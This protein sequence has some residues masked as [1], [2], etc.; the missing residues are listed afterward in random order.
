LR[1]G[2][3]AALIIGIVLAY[4][5]KIE[6][7][8]LKK[9]V[10]GG[11]AVAV[12]VSALL[13]VVFQRVA[14]NQEAFEG[15]VMLVAAV[16]V[17][18]FMEWM[19]RH[20]HRLKQGIQ[21]RID[22]LLANKSSRLAIWGLFAFAAVMVL[23][24]GVETVLFLSA[25]A[26]TT[27]AIWSFWGGLLGLAIAVIFTVLFVKGSLRVDLPRFFRVT[28]IVLLIFIV[29]L[30]V[31]AYHEFSEAGI[32]PTSTAV[33]ATVGPIVR[34]NIFFA[35]AILGLPLIIFL[36]PS[37]RLPFENH[38]GK[39]AAPAGGQPALA[40]SA[41][42]ATNN[43]AERRK[44]MAHARQQQ[45]WQRLAGV[46]GLLVI[47][48][49]CLN[50]VYARSP[51]TLSPAKPVAPQNNTVSLPV[52]TLEDGLLQR[53][54]FTENGKTLRFIVLK[55]GENKF[56]VAFD[57]CENCGD[58]GYYQD[59]GAIICMNCVAE[60]IPSTIGLTGGCN[61][62]PLPFA[63]AVDTIRITVDDLR[64]GMKYFKQP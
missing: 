45:R 25:I 37:S 30:L 58:Q 51:A 6:R 55:T 31:N 15:A 42:S 22:A 62:I 40:G 8:D 59:G 29:Q 60:I 50:F 12:V 5:H 35:I 63:V 9:Y 53:F 24:E 32:L 13:A 16:F 48:F 18:T 64:E 27:E 47:S 49:L 23:R 54:S 14:V 28:N 17:G 61:P 56:G 4:L 39:S 3:E 26:V 46:S 33:M 11:V 43:P 57:A 38:K 10:V 21:T 52:S 19:R 34:N 7:V 44:L 2:I 36:T 1:E 20:A 41:I